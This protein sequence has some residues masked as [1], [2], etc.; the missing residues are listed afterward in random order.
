[1]RIIFSRKGFD[2]GSGGGPSPILGNRPVSLPIPAS[3]NSITRYSDLGFG[4]LAE[5]ASR[6]RVSADHF[7]HEDPMFFSG[8]C[9]FGQCGTAQSHLQRQGVRLGDVFLF[10]GLFADPNGVGRH[11]RI[12]AFMEIETI[13]GGDA[14]SPENPLLSAAPRTHPHVIGERPAN[15][16]IYAGPAQVAAT[17]HP[18]LRL[19]CPTGPLKLWSVPP[20]LQETGLSYH[21]RPERWQAN[22]RLETVS[23][24][25]EFVTDIG[26]RI[27]PRRWLEGIIGAVRA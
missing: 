1:M 13:I 15:N 6:G 24:G 18:H 11:H 17:A 3:R 5:R 16:C 2:T 22:G 21:G 12:F 4:E 10:F 8:R 25:Q 27:E 9:L 7:C 14:L 26:D 23:R 20:W 19:T